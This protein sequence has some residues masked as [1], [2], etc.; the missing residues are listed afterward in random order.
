MG[1]S[2]RGLGGIVVHWD[3]AGL[4]L[5]QQWRRIHVRGRAAYPVTVVAKGWL[6]LQLARV[7]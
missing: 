7:R 2:Y 6:R 5:N 1:E 3:A 4:P